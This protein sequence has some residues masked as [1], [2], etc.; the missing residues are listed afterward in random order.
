MPTACVHRSRACSAT[1]GVHH[2][3]VRLG[4]RTRCALIVE[5]GDAR[6]VH[7]CALLLGYGAG[8]VNP[9]LAFETLDDMIRQRILVGITHEQAVKNY[10]RALNKGI[11]KV[12]SKMGV[13]TVQ[14]YC[15]A[16]VFEAVGL[17]K[18]FVDKYFTRTASR[19]AASARGRRE[20]VPRRHCKRFPARPCGR[21]SRVGRRIP[22]AARRRV[23]PVQP[24][25]GVQAAARHTQRAVQDLQGL[26]EARRRPEPAPGDAARLLELK[27][28]TQPVPLDE[29]G[30]GRSI[31]KR[32]S[33]GAMSYGSISQEAHETLAIAMNRLG[34][35]SNTGEGGEDPARYSP[36][37]PTAI[38]AGARSSRWRRPLRRDERIPRQRSDL[39]IKMAQGAKPGEG[40]AAARP[41]GVS[42]GGQGRAMRLPASASISR[43]APRHLLD[44]GSRAADLR[45]K[46]SNPRARI[47]VKL[48][49]LAGVGTVR[50]RRQA[51]ADCGAD[52]GSRRR[53]G[54]SPAHLHQACGV[55]VGTRAGG[56]AA[57][58]AC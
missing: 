57:G 41:Q 17:E 12:M 26:H 5:T 28:A 33:T 48:V 39:Q 16:Q 13:S 24:G 9:Y 49:A 38:R 44:R 27:H 6:E 23:S 47:H 7:H 37:R 29:S 52:L 35:K 56:N 50:R 14:S 11:L 3:L 4:T 42:M 10:V 21:R 45:L 22:V 58:A 55:A 34:A 25:H 36:G 31:V 30:V 15:G 18:A 53:H 2:H 40:W 8:A 43:A 46:N 32:F 1:A 20:E 51:H 19:S 54:A